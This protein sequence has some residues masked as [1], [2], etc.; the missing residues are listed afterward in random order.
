MSGKR[1]GICRCPLLTSLVAQT[2]KNLHAMQETRVWSLSQ[3]R[4]PGDGNGYPLTSECHNWVTLTSTYWY[5]GFPGGSV[6][7]NLPAI[8]REEGLITGSGRSPGAGNGNRLH[9]WARIH[10]YSGESVAGWSRRFLDPPGKTETI[11]G[12]LGPEARYFYSSTHVSRFLSV[13]SVQFL[14]ILSYCLSYTCSSL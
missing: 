14:S 8:A 3:G 11:E 5:K 6:G 13:K 1:L 10:T 9:I 12:L 4:S 7:K 2:V